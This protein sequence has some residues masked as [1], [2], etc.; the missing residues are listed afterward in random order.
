MC[1]RTPNAAANSVSEMPVE[2]KDFCADSRVDFPQ[3]VQIVGGTMRQ[4][5]N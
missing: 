3:G 5:Q 4:F 1:E 2:R